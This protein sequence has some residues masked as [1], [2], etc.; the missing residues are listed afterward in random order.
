[1]S[2][3]TKQVDREKKKKVRADPACARHTEPAHRGDKS[4][5]VWC[6]EDT[7]SAP[8]TRVVIL[9][10]KLCFQPGE[11]ERARKKAPARV[12]LQGFCHSASCHSGPCE[13]FPALASQAR[14]NVQKR[15]SMLTCGSGFGFVWKKK[16]SQ[17]APFWGA[18][19][20]V[21]SISRTHMLGHG[22]SHDGPSNIVK[23]ML[24]KTDR[25]QDKKDQN[26]AT[27]NV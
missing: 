17:Y 8:P 14:R 18:V 6:Q 13:R 11:S 23:S 12:A 16:S 15:D 25:E 7:A 27:F 22:A 21:C 24:E 5:S 10:E 3:S 20:C 1:M 9:N 19:A 26:F 2:H 4:R